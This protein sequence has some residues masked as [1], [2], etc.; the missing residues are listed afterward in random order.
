MDDMLIWID[1]HRA[2][3]LV[4]AVAAWTLASVYVRLTP[5]KR[6]D[7]Q[8]SRFRTQFLEVISFLQPRDGDGVLSLPGKRAKRRP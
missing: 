4:A 5:S 3:L 2:D 7:E 1:T 8:L 6:D